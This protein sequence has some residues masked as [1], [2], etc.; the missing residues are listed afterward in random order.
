MT[1]DTTGVAMEVSI[2]MFE[3]KGSE[4][5]RTLAA[6]SSRTEDFFSNVSFISVKV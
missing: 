4:L 5:D 1:G 6:D 3:L 2:T